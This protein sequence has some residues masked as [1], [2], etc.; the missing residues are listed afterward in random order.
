[1]GVSR[2]RGA[3]ALVACVLSLAGGCTWSPRAALTVTPAAGRGDE[4]TAI[5]VSGLPTGAT[6]QVDVT[7]T[8]AAGEHWSSHAT[9]AAGADGTLDTATASSTGGSYLGVSPT[10]SITSMRTDDAAARPNLTYRAPTTGPSTFSVAVHADGVDVTSTF[11]RTFVPD[12]LVVHQLSLQRD[13]V[14][15]T[16]VAPATPSGTQPAVLLLGGS[17]GGVAS[18]P[19]AQAFAAR[20]IPALAIAYFG[21]PGLPKQLADVPLEYF[22]TAVRWLDRQ[23]GVDPQ[24]VWLAGG[25]YGSEAALLVGARY[26]DLVHGVL[27]L[28]GGSTVTCSVS[29]GT[30]I[31]ACDRSPFTSGGRPVAFTRQFDN[32]QPTDEEAAI[33]PV[34][35]IRGPVVAVCGG[36]DNEWD[37]CRLSQAALDR[38]KEHG[39]G[40]GDLLL[41]YPDAGHFVN[42]LLAWRPVNTP[43]GS[44]DA[45]ATS[46]SDPDADADAWPKVLAAITGG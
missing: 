15:G 40:A 31:D 8:D 45:G 44:K 32:P 28:S 1:M 25:S 30:S 6:T 21:A 3:V 10:G 35:R 37:A 27:S 9:Y 11:T 5:T 12:P 2:G 22:G 36:A 14:Y 43:D 26:P 41:A 46:Q 29:P 13:H 20:G 23:P 24:R 17:D 4:P 42:F 38:R 19:L 39:T 16:Y 34:E 7:S 33:I 18:L